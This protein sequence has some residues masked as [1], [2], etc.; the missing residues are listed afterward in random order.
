MINLLSRSSDSEYYSHR[1]SGRKKRRGRKERDRHHGRHGSPGKGSHRHS[2]R[3]K[4]HSG[5]RDEEGNSK[6]S[7]YRRNTRSPRS[8]SR[9]KTPHSTHSRSR[10][11]V[12]ES[13]N[14]GGKYSNSSS[15]STPKSL[16]SNKIT[17]DFHK[18]GPTHQKTA[19]V[20]NNEGV[21][22]FE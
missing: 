5:H 21:H 18:K 11:S 17:T 9:S 22:D 8:R 10:L 1:S 6:S 16:N 14:E 7:R 19:Q 15:H 13:P 2:R 20:F 4:R 3:R 12:K